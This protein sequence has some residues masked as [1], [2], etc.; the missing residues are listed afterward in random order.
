YLDGEGNIDRIALRRVIF[1]DDQLRS[2][3]ESILH[4]L[5]RQRLLELMSQCRRQQKN[6]VAEIPL[7]FESG[8]Q[9][10]FDHVVT[11]Y[12]G[13]EISIRRVM[14]RDGV[15]RQQVKQAL[16]VQMNIDEKAKNSDYVIDNNYTLEHTLIA[17]DAV[18][19][20]LLA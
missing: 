15:S 16:A 12:A 13:P 9:H 3:L 14:A 17:V 19:G 4:P 10:E 20:N 7:L 1:A 5:V 2:E 18:L 6:L 8:W 11:V